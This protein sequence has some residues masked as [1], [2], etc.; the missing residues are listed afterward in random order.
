MSSTFLA[1]AQATEVLCLAVT[2][3]SECIAASQDIVSPV[4]VGL[5]P[6]GSA[7]RGTTSA[8]SSL[9][10]LGIFSSSRST[11]RAAFFEVCAMT[12]GQAR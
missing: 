10:R 5:R 3:D 11:H 1:R 7:V 8:K 9:D 2:H 12:A 4:T 6:E